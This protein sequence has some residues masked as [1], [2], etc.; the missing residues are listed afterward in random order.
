MTTRT[1][2]CLAD[3]TR[4]PWERGSIPA[5]ARRTTLRA[6]DSSAGAGRDDEFRTGPVENR[7]ETGD[8]RREAGSGETA[9]VIPSGGRRPEARNRDPL[10]RGTSASVGTS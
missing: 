5:Q 6:Q 2:T 7:P 9:A 1:N 3:I 8:G 10:G 4:S